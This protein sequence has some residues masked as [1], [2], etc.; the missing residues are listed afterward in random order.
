MKQ[1]KYLKHTL[2]TCMYMQHPDLLL[3]QPDETLA[4]YV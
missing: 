2:A 3:Q 1:L 4:T